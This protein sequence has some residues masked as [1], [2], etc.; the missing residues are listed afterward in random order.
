[1]ADKDISFVSERF[2]HS[3]VDVYFSPDSHV[4]TNAGLLGHTKKTYI[5]YI[6]LEP[7]W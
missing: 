7:G 2:E 6:A 1:M 5:A 4:L 3:K